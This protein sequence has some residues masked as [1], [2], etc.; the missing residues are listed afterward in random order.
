VGERRVGGLNFFW[1]RFTVGRI[2]LALRF[3]RQLGLGKEVV[4][5]RIRSFPIFVAI[6]PILYDLYH[7]YLFLVGNVYLFVRCMYNVERETLGLD[8]FSEYCSIPSGRLVVWSR[9]IVLEWLDDH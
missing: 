7:T 2:A 1:P 9:L 3:S 4:A 5:P 6:V 8:A